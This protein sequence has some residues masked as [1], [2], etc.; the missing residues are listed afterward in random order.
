MPIIW[1]VIWFKMDFFSP[2]GNQL[3]TSCRQ[4]KGLEF[5]GK[6]EFNHKW[7]VSAYTSAWSPFLVLNNCLHGQEREDPERMQK[8][9]SISKFS[10]IIAAFFC[11][12]ARDVALSAL[13]A[14]QFLPQSSLLMLQNVLNATMQGSR[15]SFSKK[16][17]LTL[18]S[19]KQVLVCECMPQ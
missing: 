5:I 15:F 1:C 9:C 12:C 10:I 16:R 18:E 8:N 14:K 2:Q 13:S 4:L 7:C 11:Q 19:L 6:M 17:P 3:Q